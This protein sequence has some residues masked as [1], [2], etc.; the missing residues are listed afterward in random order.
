MIDE[1]ACEC[2][3]VSCPPHH[4]LSQPLPPLITV[5]QGYVMRDEGLEVSNTLGGI[6]TAIHAWFN[7]PAIAKAMYGPI[8]SWDV[9]EI[10]N[11]QSLFVGDTRLS[12]ED[13]SRWNVS[14]V[15]NM[16]SMFL[17]AH[18][19]NGD[20]SRWD[21]GQVESME[22]M[23]LEANSF[24]CDLSR[25]D[26]G[27]VKNMRVM[28]ADATSFNSDLSKWEVGQVESME[29]MF[30]G[31]TSF[32]GNLSSWDVGQVEN[33]GGMFE[34]ATS[35]NGASVGRWMT[36]EKAH[37]RTTTQLAHRHS[38]KTPGTTAARTNV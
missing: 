13:I 22:L 15:V 36:E 7:D 16:E 6:R 19:F 21:V 25:W 37:G 29:Y 28:F 23:F 9:S 24:D 12:N 3:V 32:T 1:A 4:S 8:A 5:A 26:V 10:T 17:C 20:L 31:A 35:F 2:H 27:Q 34:H 38:V 30:A 33:M 14:N 18:S 11:M